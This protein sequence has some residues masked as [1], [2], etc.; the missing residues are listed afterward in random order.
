MA[1]SIDHYHLK[2]PESSSCPG[3]LFILNERKS[4]SVKYITGLFIAFVLLFISPIRITL[5][6]KM[7]L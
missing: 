2:W 4:L 7:A 3:T 6:D 5:M 1:F